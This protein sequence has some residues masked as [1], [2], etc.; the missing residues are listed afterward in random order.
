MHIKFE[1]QQLPF[2][3]ASG[4]VFT[5][6]DSTAQWREHLPCSCS[7]ADRVVEPEPHSIGEFNE[8]LCCE[9]CERAFGQ[10]DQLASHRQQ[11]QSGQHRNNATDPG[12]SDEADLADDDGKSDRRS[13]FTCPL[14]HKT[15]DTFGKRTNHWRAHRDHPDLPSASAVRRCYVCDVADCGRRFV[16]WP[17]MQQHRKS[18]HLIGPTVMRCAECDAVFYQSWRLA[19]HRR[20]HHAERLRCPLCPTTF[21]QRSSLNAHTLRMHMNEQRPIAEV[22]SYRNR[23]I[24]KYFR[25]V[26]RDGSFTCRQCDKNVALRRNAITHAEAVHMRLRDF[27]CDHCEASFFGQND[28]RKHMRRRHGAHAALVTGRGEPMECAYC[29]HRERSKV[30]LSA[31]M[32]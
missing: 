22:R 27:V 3:S 24:E 10:A 18:G 7:K 17:K 19:H 23:V 13:Q 11:C 31:H 26:P 30:R 20:V 8:L 5:N 29:G 12:T 25:V 1:T 28:L 32:L 14:C 9:F 21:V 2:C 15:F 6:A 16:D 4:E